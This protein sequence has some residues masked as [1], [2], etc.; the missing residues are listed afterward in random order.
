MTNIRYLYQVICFLAV[1]SPSSLSVSFQNLLLLSLALPSLLASSGSA[2]NYLDLLATSG[3]IMISYLSNLYLQCPTFN[4]S[5]PPLTT[6]PG[7]NVPTSSPHWVGRRSAAVG[8]PER[9]TCSTQWVP[10][11]QRA[12][13]DICHFL[14]NRNLRLNPACRPHICHFFSTDIFSTQI[15]LHTSLEQKRHEFR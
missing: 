15:F 14:H 13:P 11:S 2:L 4:W 7:S 1:F 5:F 10:A 12:I 6:F 3:V 8:V 9:E